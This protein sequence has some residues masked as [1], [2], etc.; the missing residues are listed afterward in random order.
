MVGVSNIPPDSAMISDVEGV[1][2]ASPL[3]FFLERYA[4]SYVAEMKEFVAC[5][6]EDKT[7][8]VGGADGRIAVVMGYAA[9]KSYEENRPVKI[10][11][12]GGV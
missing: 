1:H 6:R 2:G 9:R 8:E 10:S 11:E 7:P 5:V 4:D 3:F 12:V